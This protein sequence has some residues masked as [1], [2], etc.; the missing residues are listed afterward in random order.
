MLTMVEHEDYESMP[1]LTGQHVPPAATSPFLFAPRS[2]AIN[3]V[4]GAIDDAAGADASMDDAPAT[5]DDAEP[6]SGNSFP[7]LK[8]AVR[9]MSVKLSTSFKLPSFP[10]PAANVV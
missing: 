8:A 3:I 6:T 10:S 9:Q 2:A 1:G 7:L 5:S 4:G